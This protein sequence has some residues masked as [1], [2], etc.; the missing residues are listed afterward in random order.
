MAAEDDQL[1]LAELEKANGRLAQSLEHCR[2]LLSQCREQLAANSNASDR[3]FEG[4][5]AREG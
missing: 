2:N 4:E 5:R 1:K 3:P